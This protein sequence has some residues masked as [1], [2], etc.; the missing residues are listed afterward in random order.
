MK[1]PI[2]LL[3]SLCLFFSCS[4]DEDPTEGP[5][6]EGN[7]TIVVTVIEN[8]TPVEEGVTV[9]TLP[10]TKELL[11]N[12]FGQ[13]EI[14]DIPAGK[15]DVYAYIPSYG[16]GKTVTSIETD[17][18][19][20]IDV[21]LI[22]GRLLEPS[23]II[24]SPSNN[25][26]FADGEEVSFT[27]VVAD[28]N[29]IAAELIHEWSSDLDGVI[30]NSTIDANGNTS[31]NTSTLSQGEHVITLSATNNL[32][33]T[34]SSTIQINTLSPPEVELVSVKNNDGT[35][36]LDWGSLPQDIERIEII[37]YVGQGSYTE[38]T[39]A[40]FTDNITTYI[41]HTVPFAESVSYYI[42][43]FN[44]TGRSRISNTVTEE[45]AP[46]FNFQ[47][48]QAEI[49]WSRSL[50]YIKTPNN[51]IVVLDYEKQE[52][53]L[54]KVFEGTIGN[55]AIGD[56]GF[57]EELYVPSSD[58]WIYIYD[59][60]TFEYKE[61]INVGD[62]VTSVVTDQNGLVY[63]SS[64]PSPWWE[65]P[66]KVFNRSDLQF[67]DG[68][69]DFDR[70]ILRMLPSN[71]EIIEI[72]TTISPIDMDYYRFD[73][74]GMFVESKDDR[75]HGDHPLNARIFKVAPSNGYLVTSSQGAVYS[76][77]SN[78]DY[79]GVLPR[80]SGTFS[81]FEFSA[82]ASSIY[83]ALSNSKAINIFNGTNLNKTGEIS[84]G[85]YPAFIFRRGNQIISLSSPTQ[86][87]TAYYHS[88]GANSFGLEFITLE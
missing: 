11:T 41:D 57:G 21:D 23:T 2:L 15:Y 6:L 61:V 9:I 20:N 45:G 17:E 53:V 33:I 35:I 25:T 79:K 56:N 31:V 4:K 59:L 64:A 62:P 27:G 42:K 8:N 84:T 72:S 18:L 43:Y 22:Q 75:Y 54:E 37:R 65:Q 38:E 69:G 28:N 16:S 51:K 60:S 24:L 77:D 86:F 46:I 48:I 26:G 39:I 3:L 5:N 7:S 47:P 29:T 44:N 66:L 14:A 85:G 1:K 80:G 13:V 58:G 19:Q 50:I 70:C 63:S 83:G 30:S 76:A 40:V 88:N 74:N 82:D 71:N 73:S 52:I 36:S 67:V 68:G 34:S 12:S 78:M 49:H 32:G 87:E 55:F 81:D 10:A